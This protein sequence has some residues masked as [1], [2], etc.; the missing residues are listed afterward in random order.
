MT[1]PP[2]LTVTDTPFPDPTLSRSDG[3]QPRRRPEQLP[4]IP[5]MGA[6]GHRQA[7]PP[8][9]LAQPRA[10][11]LL[12]HRRLDRGRVRRPLRRHLRVPEPPP[13]REVRGLPGVIVL[14]RLRRPAAR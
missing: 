11:E 3:G 5:V 2:I 12:G 6:E 14:G 9:L 1:P 8:P 4:P 7:G 13:A 10:E